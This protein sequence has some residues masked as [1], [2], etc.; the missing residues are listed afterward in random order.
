MQE[1]QEIVD[2]L[3]LQ[4]EFAKDVEVNPQD[5]QKIFYLVTENMS[6]WIGDWTSASWAID[7]EL[8]SR[9][10]GLRDDSTRQITALR[11]EIRKELTKNPNTPRKVLEELGVWYPYL[12]WENPVLDL[13]LLQ[14]PGIMGKWNWKLIKALTED[15]NC[16]N[17]IMEY[18]VKEEYLA[19]DDCPAGLLSFAYE[20]AQFNEA[21]WVM[22][23]L[24]SHEYTPLLILENL[25]ED[26]TLWIELI[27]NPRS[28]HYMLDCMVNVACKKLADKSQWD[29]NLIYSLVLLLSRETLLK[30]IELLA[31]SQE[32]IE[33]L[34]EVGKELFLAEDCLCKALAGNR[35]TC[36]WILEEILERELRAEHP[37]TSILSELGA[38]PNSSTEI[39]KKLSESSNSSVKSAVA[40]NGMTPEEILLVLAEDTD[41][42]VF[43]SFVQRR[44]R[45]PEKVLQVLKMNKND[46][47]RKNPNPQ[48]GMKRLAFRDFLKN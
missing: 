12:F 38:N 17:W 33:M 31:L 19:K 2:Y 15:F 3:K 22:G 41:Y 47:F 4:L 18:C 20:Y 34:Y 1:T 9:D 16:P 29:F 32:H 25:V 40:L 28:S 23:V 26:D 11:I 7:N 36:F 10:P 45:V 43:Q 35:E 13:W 48:Y 27:Y 42:E 6:P 8:S 5:L 37:N 21:G 14:D 30:N 24:A 39:L 46:F 44:Y